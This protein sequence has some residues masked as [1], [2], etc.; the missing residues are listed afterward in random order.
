MAKHL[1]HLGCSFG[2]VLITTT[3]WAD[4]GDPL[5]GLSAAQ[6]AR[7]DAGLDAFTEEEVVADGLGPVFNDV[8]CAACHTTTSGAIGGGSTRTETRFGR[9][10]MNTFDP[11][12][13]RGGSLRQAQGIGRGDASAGLPAIPACAPPFQ[14]VGEVVPFPEANVSALRRT[15]PLF[16]LGLVDAVPAQTLIDLAAKELQVDPATAGIVARVPDA[17]HP[18]QTIVGR[19]GWKAQIGTLHEFS[20][21][22]YLNEMGITN[23]SFSAENCPQGL[24]EQL[25]CNPAPTLNDD[26]GDVTAFTDFMALLAPPSRATIAGASAGEQLFESIGCTSCH[27]PTLKSGPSPIAALSNKTFHPYSDFLL[28]DMGTLGDG[29]T[30]NNATGRLMRTAPLWGVRIQ[31]RLLHDGRTTSLTDAILAHDG[32]GAAAAAAFNALTANRKQ[33]LLNFLSSL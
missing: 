18:G 13:N 4:F 21:D 23:P 33:Q 9:T 10:V 31:E 25:V 32:Q 7:F 27:K 17:D 19:F 2:A 3:A 6:Q 24:C 16:G 5:P 29:I 22:A 30:Q 14:F 8:S 1:R 26:G 15:T 12:V 20:G 28:H 11:L